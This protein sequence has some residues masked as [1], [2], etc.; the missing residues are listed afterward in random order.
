MTPPQSRK[1]HWS[2]TRSSTNQKRSR[3]HHSSDPPIGA[4]LLSEWHVYSSAQ[5][6]LYMWNRR[7]LCN[8]ENIY[9]RFNV[10]CVSV[11]HIK[12]AKHCFSS[13]VIIN[14]LL[15]S[16]LSRSV[17]LNLTQD[18]LVN[19]FSISSNQYKISG[20]DSIEIYLLQ[21]TATALINS[22][23]ICQIY[24]S[25]QV[26]MVIICPTYATVLEILCFY[27]STGDNAMVTIS[28]WILHMYN[29]SIY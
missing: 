10:F 1:K 11:S 22:N 3:W 7:F 24:Y 20:I 27:N 17:D 12:Y 26:L 29:M 2:S 21:H 16:K 15:H 19:I 23:Y 8:I 9:I 13:N 5:H 4:A 14:S 18:L 6:K 25:V 28:H